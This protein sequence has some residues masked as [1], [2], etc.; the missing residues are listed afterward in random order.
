[1]FLLFALFSQPYSSCS[2]ALAIF[3]SSLSFG[4][5]DVFH[6]FWRKDVSGKEG[7]G[8]DEADRRGEA[9]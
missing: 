7:C 9:I 4:L 1:L 6:H 2:L 8:G 5:K 3:S